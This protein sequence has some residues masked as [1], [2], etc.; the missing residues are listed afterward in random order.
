MATRTF[1]GQW[2]DRVLKSDVEASLELAHDLSS[3]FKYEFADERFTIIFPAGTPI[4]DSDFFVDKPLMK[5]IKLIDPPISMFVPQPRS[6]VFFAYQKVDGIVLNQLSIC[7]R[8]SFHLSNYL[9]LGPYGI[10]VVVHSHIPPVNY[11]KSHFSL[12]GMSSLAHVIKI[13]YMSVFKARVFH[14]NSST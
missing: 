6:N 5:K 1:T 7:F 13:I 4:A 3:H 12:E 14:F 2:D 9:H 8:L 11:R 10:K